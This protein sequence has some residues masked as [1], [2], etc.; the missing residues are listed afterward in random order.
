MRGPVVKVDPGVERCAVVKEDLYHRAPIKTG[1][2]RARIEFFVFIQLGKHLIGPP[3][4]I[5][6]SPYGISRGVGGYGAG[7][8][9]D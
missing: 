1:L 7:I 9:V 2:W 8:L 6:L 3:E 4:K 5:N